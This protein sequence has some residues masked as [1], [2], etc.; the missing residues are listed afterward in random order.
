M[1]CYV[2]ITEY[3]HVTINTLGNGSKTVGPI[4]TQL[5]LPT[6]TVTTWE[7]LMFH[8]LEWIKELL[9]TIEY[10]ED[11]SNP[12]EIIKAHDKAESPHLII[13]SDG[14]VKFHQMIFGWVIAA[15]DGTVLVQGAGPIHGRGSLL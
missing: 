7:D 8:Q 12:Y 9:H 14:S 6:P 13:V 4:S 2:D 10:K 1:L 11:F 3:I 5:T 15:S